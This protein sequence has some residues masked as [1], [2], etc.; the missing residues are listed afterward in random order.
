VNGI[1]EIIEHR[2]LEPIFYIMDVLLFGKN[3]E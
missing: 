3:W 1:I 2:K